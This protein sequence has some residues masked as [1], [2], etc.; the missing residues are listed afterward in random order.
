DGVRKLLSAELV[1]ADVSPEE[2]R[3][4]YPGAVLSLR[5]RRA[6]EETEELQEKVRGASGEEASL[7]F[8]R[9]VA[10]KRELE[11]LESERRSR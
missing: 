8:D 2:A 10:A 6:R 5:I 1:L 3:R 7:L 9:V 4:R 11:R